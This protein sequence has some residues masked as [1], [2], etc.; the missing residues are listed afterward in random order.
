[1]SG[2]HFRGAYPGQQVVTGAPGSAVPL[3]AAPI[4][5]NWFCTSD[6]AAMMGMCFRTTTAC[7]DSYEQLKQYGAKPCVTRSEATCFSVKMEQSVQLSCH[8][9]MQACRAQRDYAFGQGNEIVRE[10]TSTP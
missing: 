3:V 8:P 5:G 1:M 7:Q 4:N 2:R 9:T 6:D 10:C